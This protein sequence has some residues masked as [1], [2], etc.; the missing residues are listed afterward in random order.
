MIVLN[1]DE[2]NQKLDLPRISD[3]YWFG[4]FV[5]TLKFGKKRYF[6][7]EKTILETSTWGGT[8]Y[9]SGIEKI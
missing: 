6:R 1:I 7:W 3:V 8:E 9:I 5:M 4:T 2:V